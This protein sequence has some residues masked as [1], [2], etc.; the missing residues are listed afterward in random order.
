MIVVEG[1]FIQVGVAERCLA[2][3]MTEGRIGHVSEER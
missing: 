3:R 1:F 2:T